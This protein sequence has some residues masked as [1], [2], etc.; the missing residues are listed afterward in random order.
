MT[1]TETDTIVR[2]SRTA[3]RLVR[4]F[5]IERTGRLDRLSVATLR[6][7]IERRGALVSELMRLDG[8]RGSVRPLEL[9]Q[10]LSELAREVRAS[11]DIAETRAGR[12]GVDLRL[13]RGEGLPTGIRGGGDERFLGSI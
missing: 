6:R 7:L 8:L 12:L 11:R 10:A 4:L 3:R 2:Q 9:E 13:S 1:K 5:K